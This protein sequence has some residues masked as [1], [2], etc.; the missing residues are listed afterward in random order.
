[1]PAGHLPDKLTIKMQWTTRGANCPMCNALRGRIY[2]FDTWMSAN[3]WPG[4]HLHCNCYLKVV[5][6][7]MEESDPDFFGTDLDLQLNGWNANLPGFG[8]LFQLNYNWQPLALASAYEIEKAHFLY[9][10]H[11]PIGEI[12]KRLRSDWVGFFKR[13]PIWDQFF[14]WR[15]FHTLKHFDNIDGTYSGEQPSGLSKLWSHGFWSPQ[16]W[17]DKP[18]GLSGLWPRHKP[19]PLT[20][21]QKRLKRLQNRYLYSNFNSR[22]RPDDLVPYTPSQSYH[23]GW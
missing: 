5:S 2:T 10:A 11:L 4:F 14:Q 9:G 22:L 21:R 23:A 16:G 1:M 20:A 19:K 17:W 7:E 6:V 13:S 18:P 8:S 12:I 15:V 3:V